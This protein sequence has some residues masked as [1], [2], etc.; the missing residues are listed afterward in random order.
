MEMGA[1]CRTG[2]EE[3]EFCAPA[4]S[5]WHR[6]ALTISI[7]SGRQGHS[8]SRMIHLMKTAYFTGKAAYSIPAYSISVYEPWRDPELCIY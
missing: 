5:R 6:S 2:T 3:L 4:V 7:R 1:P 8:G